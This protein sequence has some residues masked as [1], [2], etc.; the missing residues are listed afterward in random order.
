MHRFAFLR[1]VGGGVLRRF[2]RDRC[3]NYSMIVVLLLPVLTGFVGVGTEMGL[4]LYDQQ[5]EQTA[6][7]SAAFSAA[8]LYRNAVAAG[9][10][11][12]GPNAQTQ[13]IAVAANYGF[14]VASSCGT[15]GGVRTCLAP[16][17]CS[18]DAPGTGA[19]CIEV[20]NPP[21]AG[22]KAGNASAFEVVIAQS[23]QQLFSKALMSNAVVI[24]ARAVGVVNTTDGTTTTTTT[25]T[26]PC[27][28]TGC[29]CLKVTNATSVAKTAD[30]TGTT[31]LTLNGCS[32]EVDDTGTQGLYLSGTAT[33]SATD[34]YLNNSSLGYEA[35]G[36][37]ACTALT[38]SSANCNAVT[39]TIAAPPTGGFSDP[40]QAQLSADTVSP[41]IPIIMTGNA[42]C[43][44]ASTGIGSGGNTLNPAFYKSIVITGSSKLAPGTFF[45]CP[46]GRLA[47][48]GGTTVVS[49]PPFP[50]PTGCTSPY[51]TCSGSIPYTSSDGV[52]VVLLGTT[53]S[54]GSV[55]NCA[56]LNISG[57]S[58]V[59]LVPP[60]T[61]PFAGIVTT[62]SLNC[63]PPSVGLSGNQ[64][65][66]ATISGASGTNIFGAVDLPDYSITYSG[67]ATGGGT[68]CLD[69][70][71]N[72][73]QIAGTAS[74]TN[75][76]TGVG[77]TSIGNS[78]TTTTTTT[79]TGATTYTA[80]LSN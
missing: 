67:N 63:T 11:T 47:I 10:S 13:A 42:S 37:T 24:K 28:G 16:A 72:S 30:F 55:T 43:A 69:I 75:D 19:A 20:N 12:Q 51:T 49:T 41:P 3:A 2:W 34:I 29:V 48:S 68:G 6:A 50:L 64:A 31:S 79:S 57:S 5:S 35:S 59:D 65:G 17:S 18:V 39:G 53:G 77:T 54:D 15:A 25:T 21:L 52:T 61:G 70:V 27:T 71:A 46:G 76:C 66:T 73:F 36:N 80:A 62:S 40:Y 45:I 58:V 14:N 7:N 78:T 33:V 38:Q 8:V 26:K 60:S 44:S 74:L 1:T 4:W 23:P 9:N 22:P 32:L 56:F